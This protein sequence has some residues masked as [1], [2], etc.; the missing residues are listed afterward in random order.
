M[1]E[2]DRQPLE[3]RPSKSQ[4]KREASALQALGERLVELSPAQLN[5]IPLSE[6]LREAVVEAQRI[7]Q[8]G[9]RRRQLQF[10]GKLMRQVDAEPI[11]AAVQ[12]LD[13]Q[14]LR[15]A[16]AQRR[17]EQW[18]ERL[19]AEGDTALAELLEACPEADRQQLRQAV[20]SARQE[21][22]AGR[23]PRAQRALLRLLRDLLEDAGP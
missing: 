10:I 9:G 5:R 7:R 3:E 1:S 20:R 12:A 13:A 11:A 4:L 23:P 18:R 8:R 14:G 21:Q 16:A 22:Q 15:A 2:T 6:A 17:V 19:L